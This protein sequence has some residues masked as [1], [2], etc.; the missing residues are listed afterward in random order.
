[1]RTSTCLIIARKKGSERR[2]PSESPSRPSTAEKGKSHGTGG[3]VGIGN[4]APYQMFT[5]AA[6]WVEGAEGI[7]VTRTI[8]HPPIA[9]YITRRR[10]VR[11]SWV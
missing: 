3:G 5:M 2:T 11:W 9:N 4:T 7:A 6:S 1:M 8:R 10:L